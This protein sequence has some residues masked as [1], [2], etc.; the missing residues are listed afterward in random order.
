M[1]ADYDSKA[2]AISITLVPVEHAERADQVHERAIVAL[3]DGYPVEL[4]VL[5]P[6]L[7]VEEPIAAVV[8]RYDLDRGALEAAARSALAV[9]DR[10]VVLDVLAP[11]A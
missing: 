3:H 7:G 4:Q 9:P 11:A 2:N 5:Y 6:D 10:V 1:R 8:G